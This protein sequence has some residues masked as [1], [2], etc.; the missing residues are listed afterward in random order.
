[1]GN[2]PTSYRPPRARLISLKQYEPRSIV[3]EMASLSRFRALPAAALALLIVLPLLL[4]GDSA[5]AETI[6]HGRFKR[7]EIYLPHGQVKHFAFLL[8]GDGGW[9]TGL[10]SIG[11]RLASQGTLVAGIDTA[12]LY[13]NLQE[14]T[15]NYVFPDGDLENLSS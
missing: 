15:G 12:Q 14:D 2:E 10:A 7:V 6:N 8:S 1:M 5:G 13:T 9:S 4:M 11:R 3:G